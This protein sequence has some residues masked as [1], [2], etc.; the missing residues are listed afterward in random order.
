MPRRK[1]RKGGSIKSQVIDTLKNIHDLAKQ[2]QVLSR[3]IGDNVVGRVVGAVGYGRR[4]RRRAPRRGAGFFDFLKN[5]ASVPVMAGI[6]GLSGLNAGIQGLGRARRGGA[7]HA[8]L[9]YSPYAI[10]AGSHAALRL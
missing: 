9:N 5:V 2:E 10:P 3:A 4:R 8:S 6:G 1:A 7:L